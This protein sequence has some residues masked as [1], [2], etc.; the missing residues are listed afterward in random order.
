MGKILVIDDDRTIRMLLKLILN[1]AGHTVMEAPDAKVGYDIAELESPDLILLDLMLPDMNG[2]KLLSD[3]KK[4]DT[5]SKIPIIVLTGSTDQENKLSA[6]RN[7]A[8]DFI[9]K[10]FLHEEVLLRVNTQLK[11]HN[12]I[13]SLENAVSI[14][15]KDL[16]AASRI[17]KSLVPS[18]PP[19]G[20]FDSIYWIYEPSYKVGGDIFDILVLDEKRVMIYLADIAGHGVNAAMLSVIVHRFIEDY[21]NNHPN[22][23]L[24]EFM[25]ELEKNFKFE[26]FELF[27]T[28]TA[29]V[30]DFSSKTVEISNAGHPA[31]FLLLEEALELKEPSES[32]IGIGML[33]GL[34]GIYKLTPGTRFFLYT[35][36][37]TEATNSKGEIYGTERFKKSLVESRNLSLKEQVHRAYELLKSFRES[38]EFDD[39]ISIIGIKI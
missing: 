6:L 1:K 36:G 2:L 10:P 4:S 15:E 38:E 23:E 35:D 25:L 8:V 39:D 21:L 27:F 31:P 28:I 16:I 24:N 33:R 13:N 5:L 20:Y 7:G 22:F 3:L 34:T 30:F 26:Y 9:T 12:L 17:Q 14:L 19:E 29:M 11:L 18:T 37:V 32:V